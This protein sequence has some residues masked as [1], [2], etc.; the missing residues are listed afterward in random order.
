MIFSH[1]AAENFPPD[2]FA[3]VHKA[4]RIEIQRN[5]NAQM[6]SFVVA[7]LFASS[8]E[9]FFVWKSFFVLALHFLGRENFS[10]IAR[11]FGKKASRLIIG[12]K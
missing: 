10:W 12:F 7:F 2:S 1:F 6:C 5:R 9:M 4:F 3:R 8:S 11:F